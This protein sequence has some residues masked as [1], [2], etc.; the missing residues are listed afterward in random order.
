MSL[1]LVFFTVKLFDYELERKIIGA[2]CLPVAGLLRIY[3]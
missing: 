1:F 3:K 2:L